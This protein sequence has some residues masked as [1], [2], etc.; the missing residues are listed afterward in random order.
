MA[1]FRPASYTAPYR[2]ATFQIMLEDNTLTDDNCNWAL[3]KNNNNW[4]DAEITNI[5][6]T[7]VIVSITAH[8]NDTTLDRN[9]NIRLIRLNTTDYTSISYS[10]DFKISYDPTNLY[11]PVWKDTYFETDKSP[12]KYVIKKGDEIIYSGKAVAKPNEQNVSINLNR[13]VSDYL[14]SSLPNGIADGTYYLD[15]Y[16][17]DF[18]L[19][20]NSDVTGITNL[21][22]HNFYNDYSYS[23]KR[24]SIF[25]NEP[26][27]QYKDVT[28]LVQDID[29]RQYNVIS[30][31]NNSAESKNVFVFYTDGNGTLQQKLYALD[32]NVQ[33]VKFDKELLQE[34]GIGG[35]LAFRSA[36]DNTDFHKRNIVQTCYDYC[37]YYCNAYGG[38]DSLL[39][40]GNAKKK[41]K[42]DS[43]YY[44]RNADNT[45]Q[46]FAKT[47]YNNIITTTYTM[48]TDWFTDDE[49]SRLHHLLESNEVYLHNLN[50]DVV[51]PVIITNSECEYKTFTNNGR[52][53]WYNT[54]ELEVSQ[55]KTRK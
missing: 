36:N 20:E 48:Y 54:I 30:A 45:K 8:S 7:R 33:L 22:R 55:N 38:W 23:D 44:T 31:F 14:D 5:A 40:Q 19:A 11:I 39:I 47:K 42:I 2:G 16:Y 37:L 18:Y 28:M 10:F 49:Q 34:I 46:D 26:I 1:E 25:L 43:Q 52:K 27:K 17:Q 9:C 21:T 29:I 53:K 24:T 41:D 51:E 50:T 3:A 32:N 12:L 15:N 35:T 13:L 4:F 6:T